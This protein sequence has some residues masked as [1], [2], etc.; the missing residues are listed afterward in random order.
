MF[1][2]GDTPYSCGDIEFHQVE[3]KM[4]I[5]KKTGIHRNQRTECLFK[6]GGG[7]ISRGGD[8]EVV[9]RP[10]KRNFRTD[11]ISK[12]NGISAFHF[13]QLNNYPNTHA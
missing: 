9:S 10:Q 12:L 2:F 4:G 3:D 7:D 11:I 8:G 5:K 1:K 6:M 13:R